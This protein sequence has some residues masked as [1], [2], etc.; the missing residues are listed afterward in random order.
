MAHRHGLSANDVVEALTEAPAP[1][2]AGRRH[3][4]LVRVLG[5]TFVFAGIC[6]FVAL[7]WSGMTS[8]ARVVVTLGSGLSAF[9]LSRLADRDPSLRRGR[10]TAPA[11]LG[12]AAADRPLRALR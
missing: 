3:G 4:V 8:A 6:V 11:R 9:L 2:G 1:P 12:P 5:G 7:Q 10:H